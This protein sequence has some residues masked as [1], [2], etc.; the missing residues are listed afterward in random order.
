MY[1]ERIVDKVGPDIYSAIP[2]HKDWEGRVANGDQAVIAGD[3][4]TGCT[5]IN[6]ND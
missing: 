5:A 3:Q 1:F 4:K 6:S 2:G